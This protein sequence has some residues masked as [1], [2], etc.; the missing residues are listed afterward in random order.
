MSEIQHTSRY[1]ELE[2]QEFKSSIPMHLI[3]KMSEQD[4][5]LVSAMSKM[6]AQNEWIVKVLEDHNKNLIETDLRMQELQ[7]WKSMV[8][9]KW[10]IICAFLMCCCP[11]IAKV[12]LDKFIKP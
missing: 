3:N 10:G 4:Q 2:K 11:V 1:P 8:S 9:S 12:L 5:H 6:E 7:D